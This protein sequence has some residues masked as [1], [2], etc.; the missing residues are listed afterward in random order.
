MRR[1][2]FPLT[3]ATAILAAGCHSYRPLPSPAS[4]VG[5]TVKVQFSVPRNLAAVRGA[6]GDS[7]FSGV[8]ALRGRVVAIDGDTMHVVLLRITDAA[9]DHQVPPGMTVRI[10]P[11]PS[12]AVD[13]LEIDEGKTVAVAGGTILVVAVAALVALVAALAY[14]GTP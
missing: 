13:V 1:I 4:A 11:A 5:R 14:A 7:V 10:V 2:T 12:V 3:M 9:L 6:S 8:S